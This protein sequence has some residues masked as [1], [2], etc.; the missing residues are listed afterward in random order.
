VE[1]VA[2]PSDVTYC[3]DFEEDA[4]NSFDGVDVA[5]SDG[6]IEEKH[7]ELF[8]PPSPEQP[9]HTKTD[10]TVGVAGSYT[11]AGN[12]MD[13]GYASGVALAGQKD[14]THQQDTSLESDLT[15]IKEWDTRTMYSDEGSISGADVT[16]YKVELVDNLVAKV[17]ELGAGEESLDRMLE[18]LPSLLKA[19]ALKLGQPGSSKSQRDVMYFIHRYR[20]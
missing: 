3:T 9:Y 2:T 10:Q 16:I 12:S 1:S 5:E 8:N 13:S 17:R 14:D 7:Q 4:S 6:S 19:L 11:V 20:Q 15:V 18:A